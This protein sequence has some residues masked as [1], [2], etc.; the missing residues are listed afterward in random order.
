MPRCITIKKPKQGICV[1]DMRDR[2]TVYVRTATP[3]RTNGV[4][5]SEVLSSAV[6]VW[7]AVTTKEGKEIFDGTNLKGVA[8]HWI[9]I[10]YLSGLTAEKWV[11]YNGE[12]YDIIDV[13]NLDERG[14]FMLLRCSVRGTTSNPVNLT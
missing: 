10:R 6:T 14:D 9:Y 8:T 7:A 3:S 13:Q 1:G 4:D 12:Y 5:L 2:V 11:E